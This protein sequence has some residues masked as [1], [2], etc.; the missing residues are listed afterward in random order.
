MNENL[1]DRTYLHERHRLSHQQ[2]DWLL[3][4]NSGKKYVDEKI[5]QLQHVRVFMEVTDL[6]RKNG[7]P[8]VS[9]KGPL[10]SYRIYNDPTVRISHDIDLLIDA[11]M[12]GQVIQ[13]LF[14]NGYQFST[15]VFWPGTKS[16]QKVYIKHVHHL[17]FIN[18][19][20]K[21]CVEI[22]W[23][24]MHSLPVS[25]KR[26][27]EII[28]ENIKEVEF[29]GKI[30]PVLDAEME[31][32][33]LLIH[34]SR[35]EWQRL[36]WLIDI[37]DYP[38]DDIDIQKFNLL[39]SNL[40]LYRIISQVDLLFKQYFNYSFLFN[41][42]FKAPKY[43]VNFAIKSID[44][45]FTNNTSTEYLLKRL[46]YLWLLFP[47]F[48]YKRHVLSEYSLNVNDLSKIQSSITIVYYLYR[49]YSYIKRRILHA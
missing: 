16:Q 27:K 42:S 47:G 30:F 4:E 9:L 8:F 48:C 32:I 33:Y 22:H 2:I 10:L 46:R 38:L 24:L 15:D 11:E 36:K 13:I 1:K 26:Q 39:S 19:E 6:L 35:H 44:S 43:M 18:N 25:P 7:I 45:E 23:V 20:T 5:S 29:S 12:I 3:N 28:L 31:F 14:N 21:S 49:P 17:S 34:G 41:T 40:K 37:K